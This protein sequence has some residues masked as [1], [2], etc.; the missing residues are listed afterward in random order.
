MSVGY[1]KLAVY[2][3][4]SSIA[5]EQERSCS[6]KTIFSKFESSCK[7]KIRK[8]IPSN[9]GKMQWHIDST[10]NASFI[11]IARKPMYEKTNSI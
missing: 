2:T 5:C 11:F 7:L 8:K 9:I 3:Y 10:K 1:K 6:T 4:T